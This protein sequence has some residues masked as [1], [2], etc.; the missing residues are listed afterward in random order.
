MCV[1]RFQHLAFIYCFGNIRFYIFIFFFLQKNEYWCSGKLI[2]NNLFVGK[3]IFCFRSMT[4]RYSTAHSVHN[5]L[6]C[7]WAQTFLNAD[8]LGLL[9]S[10]GYCYPV[11]DSTQFL[12]LLREIDA[13]LLL[14]IHIL[15]IPNCSYQIF[16]FVRCINDD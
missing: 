4:C 7:R 3:N 8:V 1:S 11:C 15:Y 12:E 14:Q 5:G 9:Y 6:V 10:W 16:A 13:Q 2:M